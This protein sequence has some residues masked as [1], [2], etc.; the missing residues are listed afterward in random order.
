MFA[1]LVDLAYDDIDMN[2][3]LESLAWVLKFSQE[4]LRPYS[5]HNTGGFTRVVWPS[6]GT[7][8][9]LFQMFWV[10]PDLCCYGIWAANI[11]PSKH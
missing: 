11:E 3:E 7:H 5:K 10:A 2:D 4:G 6:T 9:W 8:R 1:F